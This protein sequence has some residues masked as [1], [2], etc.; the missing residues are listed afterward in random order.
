MSRKDTCP[1]KYKNTDKFHAHLECCRQCENNPFNLCP[2]GTVLLKQ[3]VEE[4]WK[5]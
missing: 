4:A 1:Q 2:V 3:S 5:R